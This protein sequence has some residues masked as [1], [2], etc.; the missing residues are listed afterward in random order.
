MGG[1]GV[2]ASQNVL[3]DTLIEPHGDGSFNRIY[4]EEKG[5]DLRDRAGIPREYANT[6]ADVFRHDIALRNRTA[7][8]QQGHEDRVNDQQTDLRGLIQPRPHPIQKEGVEESHEWKDEQPLEH[9]RECY[10]RA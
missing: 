3:L 2:D 8:Q 4:H 1:G 9:G 7:F 10:R 6:D 5:R